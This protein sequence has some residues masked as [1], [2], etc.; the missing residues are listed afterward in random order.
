MSTATTRTTRP[1]GLRL[2]R[3]RGLLIAIA[4]FVTLFAFLNIV[5]PSAYSFFD[6]SYQSG[7]GATLAL[8]AV[9]QTII[10]LTGGFDLSAGAVISLVNAILAS[11]MKDT[12]GSQIV[13]GV[14]AIVIGGMVGAF[15]GF[16]IAFLRMQSIVV[17]LASMFIVQGVT[18]L[19]MPTPGGQIPA[20]FSAFLNGTAIPNILPAPV[21]VLVV[22]LLI[23]TLI[24]H[25]R[26]GTALYA[27]GSDQDA[28]AYSGI[29]VDWTKFS[30]YVLGGCFYGAAG[31]FISAQTGSADPL[32][33]DPLLLP[34]FAAVVVGGTLLG[35]GKGGCFGSVVGAYVLMIVVNI[36]W[37]STSPPTTAPLP[38][39]SSC[40]SPCLAPR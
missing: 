3:S 8:A 7:G 22:A 9:G 1:L 24:K 35:G 5:S 25:T 32:V 23:W 29:R 37:S 6:F 40:F 21:V 31:A 16:F 30:A 33:G 15:N 28:A 13:W 2:V 4:V 14:G 38:R 10:V 20:S 11:S 26:F 18:L 36:R 27:I 12:V 39:A 19:I 34:I 17:T